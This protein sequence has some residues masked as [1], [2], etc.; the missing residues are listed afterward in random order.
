MAATQGTAPY[1]SHRLA[2]D[3]EPETLRFA[4]FEWRTDEPVLRIGDRRVPLTPRE[5]AV[6]SVLAAVPGHVLPRETIYRRVWGVEM[7]KRDRS[8]DV[9]VRKVRIKLASAAPDRVFI[10][11]HFGFGYRFDPDVSYPVGV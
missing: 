11:T 10:H 8:V 5:F 4:E 2:G 1:A 9:Y 7:P 6:F 3:G